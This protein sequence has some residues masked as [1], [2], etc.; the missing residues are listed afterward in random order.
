MK[1]TGEDASGPAVRP[2]VLLVARDQVWNTIPASVDG[3][4][5]DPRLD[6]AVR[7]VVAAL[8]SHVIGSAPG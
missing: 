2:A 8:G 3:A 4:R 6:L 1:D 7:E 5:R